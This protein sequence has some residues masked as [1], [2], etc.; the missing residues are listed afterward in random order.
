MSSHLLTVPGGTPEPFYP[1]LAYWVFLTT[2]ALK[3]PPD[4]CFLPFPL[5]HVTGPPPHPTCHPWTGWGHKGPGGTS[6]EPIS[7]LPAVGLCLTFSAGLQILAKA[8]P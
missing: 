5:S 3:T 6:L 1:F 4:T 7:F 2:P 8:T